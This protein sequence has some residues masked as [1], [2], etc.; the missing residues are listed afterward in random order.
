MVGRVSHNRKKSQNIFHGWV[1]GGE[2]K[3][4]CQCQMPKK[5]LPTNVEK[6]WQLPCSSFCQLCT[7]L[8]YSKPKLV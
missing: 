5:I 7:Y 4:G 8:I 2:G 6:G 1:G 3:G